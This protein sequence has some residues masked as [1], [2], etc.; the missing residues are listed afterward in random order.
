MAVADLVPQKPGG[1]GKPARF[2]N[3]PPRLSQ[4]ATSGV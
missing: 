4:E 2:Q 3:L 1:G